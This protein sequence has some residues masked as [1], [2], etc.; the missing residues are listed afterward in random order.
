MSQLAIIF[1][2]LFFIHFLKLKSEVIQRDREMIQK[3]F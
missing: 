3:N 1:I 2:V